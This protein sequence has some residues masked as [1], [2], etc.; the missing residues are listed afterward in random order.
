MDTMDQPA[1][2][3]EEIQLLLGFEHLVRERWTFYEREARSVL[4]RLLAGAAVEPGAHSAHVRRAGRGKAPRLF[5]DGRGALPPMA[6]SIPRR[7]VKVDSL[8]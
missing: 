2:T 8:G 5:V 6:K 4:R 3:Q 7:R 1:I